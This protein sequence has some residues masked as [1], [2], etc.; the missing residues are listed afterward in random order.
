MLV[1]KYRTQDGPAEHVPDDKQRLALVRTKAIN[2]INPARQFIQALLDFL[3]ISQVGQHNIRAT[4]DF[5][6]QCIE[7]D[8][9]NNNYIMTYSTAAPDLIVQSIQWSPMEH[10]DT[11]NITIHITVKNQGLGLAQTSRLDFYV[12]GIGITQIYLGPLS[13]GYYETKTI[14][15]FAG[16]SAH[17]LKAVIDADDWIYES[18]ETNNTCSV[19]LPGVTPPD[20]LI[21]SITWTPNPATVNSYM[22]FTITVRNAG[23]KTAPECRMDFYISPSYRSNRVIGPILPGGTDIVTIEYFTSTV[24]LR[25]MAI[26]DPSNVVTESDE[27]NNELEALITLTEP[28][29]VDFF[30]TSLNYIP[31]NPAVG[32]EVNISIKLKN[33][34]SVHAGISHLAY[35]IDDEIIEII[36][37]KNLN[38]KN[39]MINT[40]TWIA[41]PGTHTIKAIADYNDYY[42]ETDEANNIKEITITVLSPDLAIQSINWSP[43]I[44]ATGDNMDITFTIINQGT[45]KSGSCYIDYYVDGA[46]IGNQY[47]EEIA[48]GETVSRTLPWTLAYDYQSFKIIVD[49]NN[50]VFE[51]DESNNEKTAIIPAPDLLIESINYTPDEFSENETVTFT[52]SVINAGAMLAEASS[53]NFYINDVLQTTV[54]IDSLPVGS[55]KEVLFNWTALS[56]QNTFRFSLDVGD[57]IV[58][59]DESNN[60]EFVTLQTLVQA[61]IEIPPETTDEESTDNITTNETQEGVTGIL[62]IDNLPPGLDSEVA[63]PVSNLDELTGLINE[64]TPLWQNILGNRWI[65][66]GVGV[67]GV[68]A[69]SVLL[70]IRKR[71]RVY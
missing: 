62:D 54:P 24:P 69:I 61:G 28:T 29:T 59:M 15:Y 46:W 57:N 12:D 4:A 25:V 44:P 9:T 64:E 43:D 48:P 67:A 36:P 21:E 7:S 20:L 71:A 60:E 58:E 68:A 50:D 31:Q 45:Y 32:D 56:G 6:D 26:V 35:L 10:T 5:L 13:P 14:S 38:A 66:L 40:I 33:N 34:S 47:I 17:V 41:T 11:E 16:P 2:R 8:E 70:L 18:D 30:I 3:W 19:T 27:T 55:S 23:N 52:I 51:S 63:P 49:K 42:Y 53:L 1:E 39:S 65:I 22:T 37:I